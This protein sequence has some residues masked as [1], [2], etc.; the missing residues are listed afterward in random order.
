M[1]KNGN[2]KKH[3][4][5]TRQQYRSIELTRDVYSSIRE[6]NRL[7]RKYKALERGVSWDENPSGWAWVRLKLVELMEYLG[8]ELL[9]MFR[10]VLF[11]LAV[12]VGWVLVL[13]F[14]IIWLRDFK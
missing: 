10:K 12:L 6:A 5:E 1:R 11:G 8:F 7:L 4:Q 14:L 2:A 3:F 9:L 13:G